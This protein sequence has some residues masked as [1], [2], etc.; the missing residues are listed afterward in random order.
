[1]TEPP[2]LSPAPL[3]RHDAARERTHHLARRVYLSRA[4]RPAPPPLP[5]LRRLELAAASLAACAYLGWALNVAFR[6][7]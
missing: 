3:P 6:N 7:F 1:M 4:P 5:A 2:T